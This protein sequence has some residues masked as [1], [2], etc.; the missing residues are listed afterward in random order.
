MLAGSADDLERILTSLIL[1]SIMSMVNS[2]NK[3]EFNILQRGVVSRH[4]HYASVVSTLTNHPKSVGGK[5]SSVAARGTIASIV[6]TRTCAAS[7]S[8]FWLRNY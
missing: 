2:F 3:Y 1:I 5:K 4:A 6:H 7:V 8:Q